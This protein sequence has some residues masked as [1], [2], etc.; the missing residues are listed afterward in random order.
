MKLSTRGRY[1]VLALT[2]IASRDALVPVAL[3]DISRRQ[4]IST[5]YLEQLFQSMRRAGLVVSVRG[6]KGGFHLARP[7]ADTRILDV[8]MA[9]DESVSA[10][11]QGAGV[12]GG[13]TGTREQSL[14]NRLWEGLSAKIYVY[15]HSLTL[16]DVIGNDVD[17]CPALPA[18]CQR[19]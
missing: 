3:H 11:E 12:R 19:S 2:D 6:P 15:L 8:L 16:E 1:A 13:N 9:V 14:S 7:P 4:G 5:Y 18:F 10:L 17:P